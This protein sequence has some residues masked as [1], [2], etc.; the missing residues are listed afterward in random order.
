MSNTYSQKYEGKTKQY[1]RN[2]LNVSDRFPLTH[3]KNKGRGFVSC[4]CTQCR[5]GLH[6]DPT[7]RGKVKANRRSVRQQLRQG[8]QDIAPKFS[9]GYTD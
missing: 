2:G 5:Y 1:M 7:V 9:I 6:R 8:K 3:H 4:S